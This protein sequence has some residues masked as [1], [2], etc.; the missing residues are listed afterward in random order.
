[1]YFVAILG[2]L[3]I[4]GCS[5][6]SGGA[7]VQVPQPPSNCTQNS[8]CDSGKCMPDG[9]CAQSV[10][11]GDSCDDSHI[12]KGGL[13]CV[14]GSCQPNDNP[15]SGKKCEED[16][17]CDEG[18]KCSDGTCKAETKGCVEDTDCDN[19]ETCVEGSCERIHV[20]GD[21]SCLSDEDCAEE[22]INRICMPDNTCGH[23]VGL[24]EN[25]DAYA[26]CESG[27]ECL[28][29]CYELLHQDDPCDP[30][31]SLHVCDTDNGMM[32]VEGFCR[33]M[34]YDIQLGNECNSYKLCSTE[35]TCI[36]GKCLSVKGD[37]ESC[38][39]GNH[40]VCDTGFF[41]KNTKCTPKGIKC[42]QT[43][44]CTEKDSF[45]CR[46]DSCGANGYC[47]PY[48]E[49]VTHD[50]MCRFK[51][52]PGIF[53]AQIQCRWQPNDGVEA[54]SVNVEMPPL[55]GP[56]G[57][58]KGLKNVIAVYS[59]S[60]TVIR[61]INP[62]NCDTLESIKVGLAGRWY[63]YPASAD[64]DGDGLLEFITVTSTKVYVYKWDNAEQKHKQWIA[65]DADLRSTPMVFDIDGDGLAEIVGPMGHVIKVHPNGKT[66][67]LFNKDLYVD[68][69]ITGSGY[70]VEAG[71]DAALGYLLPDDYPGIAQLVTGE[72]LYTWDKSANNWKK[73][74]SYPFPS[75]KTQT[76][77]RQFPAYAD[78]GTP[79]ATAA[80]FDFTKLDGKPEIVISGKNRIMLFSVIKKGTDS[81]ESQEIMHVEGFTWGGPVTI[82]DFNKDGLPEIGIASSGL[83]GVY[84]PKCKG[85]EAGKCA[86]K[87]VLWERWSQDNSSGTTGSSL[88]D[89]DG[90]GQAE[91]VYAD[92]CFTRVYDGKTGAVLFS[93]K[94]ASVTSIEGPIIA[95]IDGDGS[96]EIVMGS[97]GD[98]PCYNDTGAKVNY[99]D[100]SNNAVDPIHEGI[101][102][103]ADED[104]PLGKNCNKTIELC[105]CTT[106]DDCNTQFAPG[107]TTYLQQYV[108]TT[109]IHPM[110][111]MMQY[112]AAK[113]KRV[114]VKNFG[115]KPDGYKDD[116]KV[117]RATRKTTDI[118]HNDMMILKDR[119]DRWVSSRT[120]WNQHA[121]NIINIEDNGKVPTATQ[122][123]NNWIKKHT[124]LKIEITGAERPFYN[125]YRLNSQGE[126]GAGM[127]P[128]ITG[129]FLP[130]SI[131]GTTTGEDG[132]EYHLISGKLCNRGTK[133]VGQNLPATFFYYDESAPNHQG[134][135]ICTSYTKEVV[136]IGECSLV[137][138]KI[139]EEDF[140]ELAGKTVLMVSNLD[141]HGNASTVECNTDN[142]TDTSVVDSCDAEIIIN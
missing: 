31:D 19:G 134:K 15:S 41:C 55:V 24:G 11:E 20:P 5:D 140:K 62:D 23:Y 72:G 9:I 3:S 18:Q 48:D 74:I 14:S 85:Y 101:R 111:G 115:A 44:D 54:A 78:F 6:D 28:G 86:D 87:Y 58:S 138:C 128:D 50:E 83:F 45:C 114:K 29:I 80:D 27:Y 39:E 43:S 64:L 118:G 22:E 94:R 137:G 57:N 76:W 135:T 7:S 47:I 127:A 37:G 119:L 110:V 60:P 69:D 61:F 92:E 121:Y 13:K 63:N 142:N 79:G 109:P 59:Y 52:K 126:Y 89:F 90:D 96:A 129:R 104:C 25:C 95:D 34:E 123:F 124:D 21:G 70:S 132:K 99:A 120:M 107:K 42:S 65:V 84:D 116:Y 53:E 93:A 68:S 71:N 88:F 73:L 91:A 16:A 136:G 8:D 105:T 113:G 112:D 1:M 40:I 67:V 141:E 36:D 38:D 102:C 33:V 66:D 106:D 97:D 103:K 131:C 100:G 117:C 46:D 12:C 82:G 2:V 4:Y 75:Y 49:T 125:N 51:T 108:C 139:E 133:P 81:Y 17:D 30:D 122:W 32:C 130:G 56:F 26:H 10:G 77:V 35:L 98:Q